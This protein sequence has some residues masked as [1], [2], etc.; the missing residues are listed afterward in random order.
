ME[1][2]P[3]YY[4]QTPVGYPPTYSAMPVASTKGS[5]NQAG[6][7]TELQH[8]GA[9]VH[10][11]LHPNLAPSGNFPGP[12]RTRSWA[13]TSCCHGHHQLSFHGKSIKIDHAPT[14]CLT[15]CA[16]CETTTVFPVDSVS[17]IESSS[18]ATSKDF[19]WFVFY[20]ILFSA[21]IGISFA[22][23]PY[24]ASDPDYLIAVAITLWT[25]G[26]FLGIITLVYL[27]LACRF[28]IC[29]YSSHLLGAVV[30][31]LSIS[32]STLDFSEKGTLSCCLAT[33]TKFSTLLKK[34]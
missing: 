11:G 25:V 20:L 7:P 14:C 17:Y 2:Q 30:V 3:L 32:V 9:S 22:F 23:I 28:S 16:G 6:D 13:H 26:G 24:R 27:G 5:T 19:F 8:S 12:P 18:S 1:Q 34:L 10:H 29:K 4:A 33:M 31:L 21:C 15:P